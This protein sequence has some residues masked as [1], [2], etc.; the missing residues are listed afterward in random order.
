MPRAFSP[1]A[2]IL[3]TVYVPATD[4]T[5]CAS[6]GAAYATNRSEAEI[7]ASLVVRFM[8]LLPLKMGPRAPCSGHRLRYYA[9]GGKAVDRAR[10]RSERRVMYASSRP[11]PS[12]E[13]RDHDLAT[14]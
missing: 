4:F 12:N 5:V 7:A 14:R 9:G 11:Q 8:G 2:G 3:M 13:R 6:T 10:G 1:Y